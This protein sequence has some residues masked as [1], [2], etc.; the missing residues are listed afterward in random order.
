EKIDKE[1]Q[2]EGIEFVLFI[3]P[4]KG[5]IYYE[6]MPDYIGPP[7]SPYATKQ[8]VEYLRDNTNISVVYPYDE[9]MYAKE[10]L[11]EKLLYYKTDTHWNKI[12]G[13]IG[14]KAMLDELDINIP[15]ITSEDI[16]IEECDFDDGDLMILL[17]VY[18]MDDIDYEISGYE[19]NC[20]ELVGWDFDT[21][22][23]YTAQ[24]ADPRTIY[25]CRDSFSSNMAEYIGSQFEES[26]LVHRE[27]YTYEDMM[28]KEPDIFVYQLAER[29]VSSKMYFDLYKSE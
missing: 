11:D 1:L 8:L 7:V 6:Y 22:I 17:N 28:E 25:I 23:Q 26:Y 9:L 13:Y 3:V 10:H 2:M 21:L 24:N 20:V 4:N 16:S 15:D 18:N 19:T 5:R 14:A 12:G 29:Y 27:S